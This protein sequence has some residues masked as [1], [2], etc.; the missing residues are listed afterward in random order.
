LL[1][2]VE[3]DLELLVGCQKTQPVG[4]KSLKTTK[5]EVK[6]TPKKRK[7]A[8]RKYIRGCRG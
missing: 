8:L 3:T 2:T 6:Q 7:D 1:I 4:D 5:T